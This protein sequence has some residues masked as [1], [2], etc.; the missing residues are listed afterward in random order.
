MNPLP[1]FTDIDVR[2][3]DTDA[4]G[5][6]N[7]AVFLTYL[8]VARQAYWQRVDPE[9]RYDR[10]PFILANARIDFRHPVR[11]HDP[12]RIHVGVAWVGRSSFAMRYEVRARDRERLFADAESVQVT[13]DYGSDRVVPL[14]ESLRR[15]FERI[16]GGPVPSKPAA[17]R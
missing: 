4:M 3:R 10:V 2:F 11:V 17:G 14:P 12:V 7:N 8:E 15:A 1:V 16:Q 13:F 9:C 5:H 6:V